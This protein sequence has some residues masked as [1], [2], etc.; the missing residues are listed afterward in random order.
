[1]RVRPVSCVGGLDVWWVGPIKLVLTGL[2]CFVC[3][4]RTCW[5]GYVTDGVGTT[6]IFKNLDGSALF[7]LLPWMCVWWMVG[8]RR[9]VSMGPLCLICWPGYVMR[10]EH[11]TSFMRKTAFEID[12]CVCRFLFAWMHTVLLHRLCDRWVHQNIFSRVHGCVCVCVD[13]C[14]LAWIGPRSKRPHAFKAVCFA[15]TRFL[16]NSACRPP[17]RH[18]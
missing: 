11:K 14:R 7:H 5:L 4:P 9:I 13:F 3:W 8:C 2:L 15:R 12:G 10:W 16:R 1:M 17:L 18:N 6:S